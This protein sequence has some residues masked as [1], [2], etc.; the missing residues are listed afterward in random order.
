MQPFIKHAQCSDTRVFVVGDTVVAAVLR[1]AAAGDFRSNLSQHG[2]GESVE[3]DDQTAALAVSACSTFNLAYA[4]V[5]VITTVHGPAVLEVNPVPGILK[6]S[7]I[8]GV[9]IGA[10]IVAHMLRDE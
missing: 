2:S 7:E 5:D 1:T 6:T 9:D 3:V 8:T 10:A 4:G